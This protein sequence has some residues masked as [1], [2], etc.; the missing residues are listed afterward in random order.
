M[1][2]MD[3]TRITIAASLITVLLLSAG[4]ASSDNPGL[5]PRVITVEDF[6]APMPVAAS[7]PVIARSA[8][9]SPATLPPATTQ[10]ML[11]ARGPDV[12]VSATMPAT[13][14]PAGTRPS[15]PAAA[16][17]TAVQRPGERL[18]QPGDRIIVDS[19]IGQ[20]SGQP[21][22]ADEFLEPIAGRLRNISET[23]KPGEFVQNA[24]P[25]IANQLRQVVFSDLFLA[26]AEASLTPEQQVG[27]L[28]FVR[29]LRQDLIS[30][31]EGLETLAE[32]R[33]QEEG[34]TLQQTVEERR[35]AALIARQIQE[36]I[37]PRVIVA[38]KDVEREYQRRLAEFNPP[39]R[40]TI[41]RLRLD[42]KDPK[43]AGQIQ[44]VKTHLAAG[45]DFKTIGEAIGPPAY[46]SLGALL[47]GPGGLSDIEVNPKYKP[48]LANLKIGETT[49]PIDMG[50]SNIVWLHV[51][52]IDQPPPKTLFEVQRMLILEIEH[53][54]KAEE[55]D[56]YV[57]SLFERGIFD[58]LRDMGQRALIVARMRYER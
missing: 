52:K 57:N 24:A 22:F 20:V 12:A 55:Q 26:E 49:Q 39:A 23:S 10:P 42:G 35:D 28:A 25:I 1:S 31:N 17:T 3:W 43:E 8:A 38:W 44:E 16:P 13:T 9:S 47:M 41:S 18:T 14:A 54:R 15:A 34:K 46:G 4:C 7:A 37:S 5:K 21:I 45:E 32:G 48:A 6:S 36:R 58:D 19:V 53:R 2:V 27:L 11:V 56:K 40:V 33:S 29:R 51:D 50:D 30:R